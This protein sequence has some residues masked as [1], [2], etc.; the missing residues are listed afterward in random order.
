MRAFTARAVAAQTVDDL[1][2]FVLVLAE[3]PDG[4]GVRLEIQRSLSIDAQDRRLGMDTYCLVTDDGACCYGGV[5]VIDLRTDQLRIELAEHAAATL[6]VERGFLIGF[7]GAEHERVR[8]AV[9]ILL[10]ARPPDPAGEG[11]GS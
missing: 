11:T 9:T 2:A 6:G 8:A 3:E 5:V 10:D 7:P 4:G 1:D